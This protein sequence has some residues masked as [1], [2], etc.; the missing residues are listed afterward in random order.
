M[1]QELRPAEHA[2]DLGNGLNLHLG[3]G[4]AAIAGVVIGVDRHGQRI[5]GARHRMRRLEHLPGIERVE[6]GVVVAQ[7]V[8]GHFENA[9]H[10][11]HLRVGLRAR[12][13]RP[14]AQLNFALEQLGGAGEQ[15]GDWIDGHGDLHRITATSVIVS[16]SF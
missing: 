13:E 8:R 6:V 9:G 15:A 2:G 10:R 11:G 16:F 1:A 7:P 12:I 4:A 14:A 3:A 5:G